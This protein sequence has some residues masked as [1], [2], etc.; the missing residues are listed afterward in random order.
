MRVIASSKGT[1]YAEEPIH[2]S[3]K[4]TTLVTLA[5]VIWA[6][7]GEKAIHVNSYCQHIALV[8]IVRELSPDITIVELKLLLNQAI[9]E[10]QNDIENAIR[11]SVGEVGVMRLTL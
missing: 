9:T 11:Q 3:F 10:A 8:I 5:Y 7:S 1:V 6:D 4:G 2:T